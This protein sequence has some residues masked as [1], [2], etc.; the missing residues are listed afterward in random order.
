M[1]AQRANILKVVVTGE[2]DETLT[3]GCVHHTDTDIYRRTGKQPVCAARRSEVKQ[4][5][6]NKNNNKTTTMH[7]LVFQSKLEKKLLY[8]SKF[9]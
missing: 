7:K 9:H 6:K 8:I 4:E 2:A 5:V 1:T 3:C